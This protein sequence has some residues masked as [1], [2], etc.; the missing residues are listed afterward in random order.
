MHRRSPYG[1]A[2]SLLM[3]WFLTRS[4]SVAG[5]EKFSG[6]KTLTYEACIAAYQELDQL[7]PEAKLL[8]AGPTDCGRSLHLFLIDNRNSYSPVRQQDDQRL[9][10]FINNGIHPGEPDGI[11]A[12][13]MLAKDLLRDPQLHALLDK[14]I[15]AIVPVF[16]IDGALQRGCCSRANQQGPDAYGFRGNAQYLDLNRDFMKVDAANTRSLISLLIEWN[17]DILID[18]HVSDGADYA[19]HMTL[20]S[21]AADKQTPPL[22][23]LT[24]DVLTPEIFS[25]MQATG[26]TICPYV[27]T[28]HPSGIPDSGIVS[29]LETPRFL[30]GWAALHHCIGFITES[31]MLK[32]F[33]ERVNST[34]RILQAIL[35]TAAKNQAAIAHARRSALLHYRHG[36]RFPLNWI[37]DTTRVGTLDFSGYKARYRTSKVTGLD[38][39]YYDHDAPYRKPVPFYD[40]YTGI[41]ST[42]IPRYYILPQA[43]NKVAE[44]LLLNNVKMKRLSQDSS[45]DV[46]A[47]R[48]T[49]YNTVD[50]PYEGHYLHYQVSTSVAR[51]KVQCF[52]GDW[53]ISTDQPAARY[54][55]EALE[56]TATDSYFNW[57]FFDAVLQQKEWFSDYVFEDVAAELLESQPALKRDFLEWRSKHPELNGDAFAQLLYI[58][59][60]SPNFETGYMR[61]P[62]YRID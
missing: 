52:R 50:R 18:T 60:H 20:I 8:E 57:G 31:H 43:W 47:Y 25:R 59:R 58:Y 33:P 10:V 55:F 62:V 61:Y 12:S 4:L 53:I 7:Y 29:F 19:A 41:D 35:K 54:V 9:V 15:I 48:I 22:G 28:R 39:L 44:L 23:T 45:L 13:L 26:D 32:P 14:L 49:N 6:N 30:S 34:H 27:D 17:P 21:S 16:N 5:S 46:S 3:I 51:E 1:F 37:L 24:R 38:R 2:L 40:H 42:S 36:E 11:D 56:P